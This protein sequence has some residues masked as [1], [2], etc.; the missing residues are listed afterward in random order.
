MR[1]LIIAGLAAAG[2]SLS[3]PVLASGGGGAKQSWS[4]QGFTGTFDRAALRRGFQVYSEV[5]AACHSLKYMHY[6]NL[7]D[8]G[9]TEEEVDLMIKTNP[10]R[11]L[12][13]GL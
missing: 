6:R 9:F 10:A 13:L 3:T 7:M 4:F 1:A 8:I 11:F 5:C 2:L 12:G